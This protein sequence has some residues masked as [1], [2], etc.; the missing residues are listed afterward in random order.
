MSDE[1]KHLDAKIT[2][3]VPLQPRYCDNCQTMKMRMDFAGKQKKCKACR[4]AENKKR[5]RA[6]Q[7]KK[8]WCNNM[9]QSSKRQV[10]YL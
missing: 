8:D 1:K 5:N 2:E 10:D 3:V 7:L 6:T 9:W 4:N